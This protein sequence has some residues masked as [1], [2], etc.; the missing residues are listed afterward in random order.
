MINKMESEGRMVL[1]EHLYEPEQ[2]V[3]VAADVGLRDTTAW[4]FWQPRP[5]GIAVIDFYENSG[6]HI[7]HYLGMLHQKGYDY[8]EIWLPFD[9]KAKTLATR[10]STVEQFHAPSEIRPDLYGPGDRLP[11]RILPKLSIQHGID[12]ARM[13]LAR[14][15][16]DMTNCH[17]GVDALRSYRRQWHEHAQ[18]FSDTPMHDWASNAA[19]AFRY[20]ALVA[21]KSIAMTSETSN[22]SVLK[23]TELRLD[24]LFKE[25]ENGRNYGTIRI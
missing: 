15:H 24:D 16:F 17:Q 11:I 23:P 3:H 18:T 5:D 7:D 13:I 19:D 10:R 9:A 22:T 2:K 21:D 12:A 8:H 6:V 1:D 14:T 4:W 25:N 20:L